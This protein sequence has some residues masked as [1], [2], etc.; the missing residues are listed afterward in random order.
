MLGNCRG[1]GE[2]RI[3]SELEVGQCAA[4]NAGFLSQLLSLSLVA[5]L[6][7]NASVGK[8]SCNLYGSSLHVASAISVKSNSRFGSSSSARGCC[9]SEPLLRHLLDLAD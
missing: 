3:L 2:K 9:S 4:L 6:G 1:I 8:I 5:N 7:H